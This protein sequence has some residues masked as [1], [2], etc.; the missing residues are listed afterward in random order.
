MLGP[1]DGGCFVVATE[2]QPYPP[3][4]IRHTALKTAESTPAGISHRTRSNSCEW[5]GSPARIA[6]TKTGVH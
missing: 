2:P 6:G 3:G 4:T 1:H 5:E